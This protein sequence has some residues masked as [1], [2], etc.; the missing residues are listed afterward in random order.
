[1]IANRT[2]RT[3]AAL[4]VGVVLATALLL[5]GAGPAAALG[6]KAPPPARLCEKGASVLSAQAVRALLRRQGYFSIRALRYR[7]FEA[8]AAGPAGKGIY[9]ATASRGFGIVRWRLSI[10][11]CTRQVVRTPLPRQP[12]NS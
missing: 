7:R 3:I 6:T 5:T 1:M 9:L 10:D 2:T 12:Q 4:A 11:P 8:S